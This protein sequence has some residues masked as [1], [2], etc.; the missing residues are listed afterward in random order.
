MSALLAA[1]LGWLVVAYLGSLIVLFVAGLLRGQG[2][3]VTLACRPGALARRARE[4]G[5]SVV[6]LPF[7]K[8]YDAES[9]VRLRRELARG[10]SVV[11]S[12]NEIA[13][14]VALAA[15]AGARITHVSTQ[16]NLITAAAPKRAAHRGLLARCA[17]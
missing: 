11:H 13:D 10:Y 5:L 15:A 9:A 7:R 2:A 1:P 4:D 17:A 6:E 3:D 16:P 12:F 14:G 8:A